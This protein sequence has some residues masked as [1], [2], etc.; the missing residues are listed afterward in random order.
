MLECCHVGIRPVCE[1]KIIAG[2]KGWK[3]THEGVL[4]LVTKPDREVVKLVMHGRMIMKYVLIMLCVQ[5][6]VCYRK[7]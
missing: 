1:T 7:Q 4:N 6:F 2:C 5:M 3:Y